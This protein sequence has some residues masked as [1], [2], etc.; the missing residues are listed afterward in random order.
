VVTNEK[1][2]WSHTAWVVAAMKDMP[3]FRDSPNG[4]R[5]GDAVRL[6]VAAIL[7]AGSNLP[8]AAMVATADP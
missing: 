5:I 6:F 3:T 1:V 4:N 7:P 2:V 8:I